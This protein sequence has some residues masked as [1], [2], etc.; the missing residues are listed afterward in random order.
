MFPALRF[1]S[2][3]PMPEKFTGRLLIITID[4]PNSGDY[5]LWVVCDGS[6]CPYL[7]R[8]L[9]VW[10]ICARCSSP[11]RRGRKTALR[12]FWRLLDDAALLR[13]FRVSSSTRTTLEASTWDTDEVIS[14]RPKRGRG[15][16][17]WDMGHLL[18][19]FCLYCIIARLAVLW[20]PILFRAAKMTQMCQKSAKTWQNIAFVHCVD[21]KCL[22]SCVIMYLTKW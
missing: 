17:V 22:Q 9:S 4:P 2:G 12:A 16:E 20:G 14:S 1:M 19:V 13:T 5:S 21:K 10:L 7:P 11:M 3:F 8:I 15:D 6:Q 18:S